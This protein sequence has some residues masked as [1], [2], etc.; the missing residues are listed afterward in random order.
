MRWRRSGTG[1]GKREE[2]AEARRGLL[3]RVVSITPRRRQEVV[4]K[5]FPE[6][7]EFTSY[8]HRFAV[9]QVLSVLIAVFGL[10]SGSTSIV[11][12]AMLVAPLMNPLLAVG[13]AMVSGWP[14]REG[15]FFTVVVVTSVLS[16]LLAWAVTK[17]L[18]PADLPI[19]EEILSRTSPTVMDLGVALAAGAAGAYATVRREV[20]EALSGV[21][22]AVALV[23]PLATVGITFGLGRN[24]LA[25]GALLLYLTNLA[26]IVFVGALVFLFTGFAPEW[27]LI[28]ESNRVR[29]GLA[30][31]ALA[32]LAVSVPLARHSL[33]EVRINRDTSA[34]ATRVEQW[35]RGT[36]LRQTGVTVK[37]DQVNVDVIG[38]TEPPP[39]RPLAG[40]LARAFDH[41][42]RVRVRWV[43]RRTS[44][45]ES[46]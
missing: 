11:I 23:P 30:V 26:V 1:G 36:E 13:A 45:A 32:V 2:G 6:G 33:N 20:G 10:L 5:L 41:P 21:A 14:A 17:S 8:L 4:E 12:G 40:K 9:M 34:A 37:G 29:L 46:R 25:R 38:P 31:A 18:A 27:R 43:Q 35:L 44:T 28:R 24:D 16:A 15:K 19:S 3:G 22:V 39:A 7:A 42:V